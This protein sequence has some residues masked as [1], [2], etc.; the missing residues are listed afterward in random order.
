[1]YKSRYEISD[2]ARQKTQSLESNVREL[3]LQVYELS[4]RM[5][6][7]DGT[8]L[9]LTKAEKH[10]LGVTIRAH[11]RRLEQAAA[12]KQRQQEKEAAQRAAKEEEMRAWRERREREERQAASEEF[13]TEERRLI[14]ASLHPDESAS[15]ER[16]EAAFKVFNA[17]VKP[18]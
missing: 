10:A 17:K 13:T 11:Q 5:L 8:P 12:A 6:A 3:R 7:A 1:M 14:L 9:T 16:R 2:T 15:K 4:A 18:Q